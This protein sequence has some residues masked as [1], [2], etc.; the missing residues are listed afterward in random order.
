MSDG[1]S[2]TMDVERL[3]KLP[4][5]GEL[6]HH[7][8]STIARHVREAHADTGEVLFAEGTI[9]YELLVIEEGTAE[10]TREGR[11][12]GAIGPGD[13]VGE[14]GLLQQQRRTATVRAT[15]PLR[16]VAVAADDLA[17]IESEMPEIAGQLREIMRSRT[18]DSSD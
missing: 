12:L 18:A 15:S 8:L 6:D 7:D 1:A 5:F 11:Q 3:R 16:A 10:V 2:G 14:I 13:V 9:P 4:L 17:V